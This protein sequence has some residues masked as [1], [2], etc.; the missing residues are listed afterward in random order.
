MRNVFVSNISEENTNSFLPIATSFIFS[1]CI[2]NPALSSSRFYGDPFLSARIPRYVY[3]IIRSNLTCFS[4]CRF[5]C[6]SD[7]HEMLSHKL[8]RYVEENMEEREWKFKSFA[9]KE[10]LFTPRC[11]C[12]LVIPFRWNF[13]VFLS[14]NYS[15][16]WVNV[17]NW[18][19][20]YYK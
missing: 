10:Y 19:I 12:I 16:L 1:F 5:S 3:C 6:S 7:Y 15:G 20:T 13:W 8:Q 17:W 2:L 9:Q 11:S 4:H 18:Y 14:L